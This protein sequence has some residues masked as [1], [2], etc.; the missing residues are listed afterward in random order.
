MTA[1]VPHRSPV[2]GWLDSIVTSPR[3][4][5]RLAGAIYLLVIVFGGFSEGVVMNTLVAGD[6]MAATAAK[7]ASSGDLWR[8]TTAGDLIVPLIAVVQLWI[9]YLLLRPVGRNGALLFVL[10]NLASLAAET[11]SKV[12]LLLVE[13]ALHGHACGDSCSPDQMHAL[14]GF[15]LLAHS[16]AFHVALLLFGAACLIIGGLIFRSGYI[17]RAIGVLMQLAGLCYL[18]ASFSELFIPSFAARITPWILLPSLVGESS[19]CLWLLIRGVNQ[20]KWEEQLAVGM[21]VG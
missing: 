11:V 18:T 7:I 5:A 6:D 10:L 3:V 21:S 1:T 12:F 20:M 9:E 17:P 15:A 13:P 2:P 16:V 4:Y 14:A 19:F 8:F